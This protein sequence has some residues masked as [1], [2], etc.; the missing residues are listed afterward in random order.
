VGN[1]VQVNLSPKLG[2]GFCGIFRKLCDRKKVD[3]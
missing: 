3:L 1:V 2:E